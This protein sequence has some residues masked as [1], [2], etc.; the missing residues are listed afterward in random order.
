MV[1]LQPLDTPRPSLV[2]GNVQY[3]SAPIKIAQPARG[4]VA[5][6]RMLNGQPVHK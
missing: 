3:P 4:L 6:R 5:S 1:V 2:V